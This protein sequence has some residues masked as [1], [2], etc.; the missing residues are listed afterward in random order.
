MI[1]STVHFE[2][3]DFL[4]RIAQGWDANKARDWFAQEQGRRTALGLPTLAASIT[5]LI[6][7]NSIS[8]PPTLT[9]DYI[10]IQT[11]QRRLEKLMYQTACRWTFEETVDSLGQRSIPQRSY[12]ELHAHLSVLISDED[13]RCQI[14]QQRRDV[15]LEIV[16][17]A[18]EVLGIQRVPT[19]DD[20]EFA[21]SNLF[22]ANNASTNVFK[23]L[24]SYLADDLHLLVEEQVDIVKD[25][26]PV[27]ITNRFVLA[28][29]TP[30]RKVTEQTDLLQV[31]QEV[32]H[33]SVLHWRV[34]GPILYDLP[35][36][37]R[38]A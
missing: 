31:A 20:L 13:S 11:L 15:V 10:R 32:A 18:Y 6:I 8:L 36:A 25:L 2:Q 14:P 17:A 12:D 37:T 9:L 19:C 3:N 38:T 4:H 28:G 21:E 26:T 22:Y 34:W 16:R 1:D 33:I 23:S 30:F 7:T 24:Q 27:Q 35:V 29:A 5:D